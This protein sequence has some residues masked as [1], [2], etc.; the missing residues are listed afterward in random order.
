M[1]VEILYGGK[2]WKPLWT[3]LIIDCVDVIL[4]AT[5]D[6]H[7][8]FTQARAV[9]E[10]DLSLR[11]EHIVCGKMLEKV[12]GDVLNITNRVIGRLLTTLTTFLVYFQLIK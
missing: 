5:Q 8:H 4:R 10:R 2:Y 12:L 11:A 1:W 6:K 9:L 3:A 7:Y